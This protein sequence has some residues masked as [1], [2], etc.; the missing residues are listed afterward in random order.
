VLDHRLERVRS[1]CLALPE[2]ASEPYGSHT[3]FSVRK[4]KFAYFLNSHHGD[5]ISL[6]PPSGL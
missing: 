3:S 6:T 1:I 2:A 5:G 4:K